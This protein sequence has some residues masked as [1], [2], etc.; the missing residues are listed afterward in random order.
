MNGSGNTRRSVV[1]DS[2]D[3]SKKFCRGERSATGVYYHLAHDTSQ[4]HYKPAVPTLWG[5]RGIAAG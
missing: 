2:E 3:R 5:S 1:G 4:G